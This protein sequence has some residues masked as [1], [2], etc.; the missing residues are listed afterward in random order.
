[1]SDNTQF[2]ALGKRQ[3]TFTKLDVF[4]RPE[5]VTEVVLTGDE[6]TAFCPITNQ[7]DFYRF[8]VRYRPVTLCIESKTFKLLIASFREKAAF[9]EALA[10]DLAQLVHEATG[11]ET[12]VTL[13]QQVRGG[14]SITAKA[15]IGGSQNPG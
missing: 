14:I 8:E 7:P 2:T 9:A 5:H 4:E 13:I 15:S 6:L 10:S 3:T 1:M 11:A 12:D